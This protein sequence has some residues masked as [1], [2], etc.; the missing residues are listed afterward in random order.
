MAALLAP[1][2]TPHA[3]HIN[4]HLLGVEVEI[5]LHTVSVMSPLLWPSSSAGFFLSCAISGS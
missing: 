2:K 1:E 3:Y 5:L 4:E